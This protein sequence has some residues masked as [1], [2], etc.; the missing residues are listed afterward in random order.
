VTTALTVIEVNCPT[1]TKVLGGG[2]S[3]NPPTDATKYIP[4]E[5]SPSGTG[6]QGWYVS[7]QATT[8]TVNIFVWAI[9][10]TA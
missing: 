6:D 8:G 1:G 7:G 3:V 4:R 2:W 5:S 9:C 10:A